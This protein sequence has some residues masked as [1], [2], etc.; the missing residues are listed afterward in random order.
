MINPKEVF[1]S[2][3]LIPFQMHWTGIHLK[4][5]QNMN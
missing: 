2:I 3:H 1:L 4:L 5:N